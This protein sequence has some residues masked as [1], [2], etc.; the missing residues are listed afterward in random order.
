M[1]QRKYNTV[2]GVM[3][4]IVEPKEGDICGWVE[5]GKERIP[6]EPAEGRCDKPAVIVNVGEFIDPKD[7]RIKETRTRAF[8]A[9]CARAAMT[10]ALNSTY[11]PDFFRPGEDEV[12]MNLVSRKILL[13][14]REFLTMCLNKIGRGTTTGLLLEC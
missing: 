12:S 2:Y 5:I 14:R 7:G 9:D 4:Y 13:E 1:E 11:H 3:A 6:F 10:R 8:C